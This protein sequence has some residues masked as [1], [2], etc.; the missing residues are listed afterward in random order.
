[1]RV[2][3]GSWTARP[4][5]VGILVPADNATAG[6]PV[7]WRELVR[8]AWLHTASFWGGAGAVV[9]P[10]GERGVHAQVLRAL[11]GYDPD[12]VVPYGLDDGKGGIRRDWIAEVAQDQLRRHTSAV[13]PWDELHCPHFARLGGG[14]DYPLTPMDGLPGDEPDATSSVA[15][16]DADLLL[17]VAARHGWGPAGEAAEGAISE[18]GAR[19]ALGGRGLSSWGKGPTPL[20]RTA[21]GLQ[22]LTAGIRRPAHLLLV[23][24][25]TVN[26]HC[27]AMVLDRLFG[28]GAAA[29]MPFD[30]SA[31]AVEQDDIDRVAEWAS[32]ESRH[33][34]DAPVVTSLT[35]GEDQLV[36]VADR[37]ADATSPVI[38]NGEARRYLS[39]PPEVRSPG[40][41]SLDG[42]RAQLVDGHRLH[43]P[44]QL[45]VGD[46]GTTVEPQPTPPIPRL[47]DS[48][49][50]RDVRWV[51]D[52]QVDG[53]SVP[54]R[55]VF[56][57]SSGHSFGP[58]VRAG[59]QG[60][61]WEAV[62]EFIGG[63]DVAPLH[64]LNR[65]AVREPEIRSVISELASVGS[66]SI[67]G[68]NVS[69]FYNG[70]VALW[71]GIG[72]LADDLRDQG[73][74]AI[75]ELLQGDGHIGANWKN[76][77]RPAVRLSDMRA[78]TSYSLT[79][80]E[81]RVLAQ[82]WM[83]AGILRR[84]FGLKCTACRFPAFY[85]L[86]V[87]GESWECERCRTRQDLNA[88]W[89]LPHDEPPLVYVIDEVVGQAL[90]H[91]IEVPALALDRAGRATRQGFRHALGLE[92]RSSEDE[93]ISDIDYA[94]LDG[95]ELV[96]GEAKSN[97][98]IPAKEVKKLVRIAETITA[99]R[100]EFAT[101]EATWAE[102]S[103]Q[104]IARYEGNWR[105]RV[106]S[107]AADDFAAP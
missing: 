17:A 3:R 12:Y 31:D 25:S 39:K 107:I 6:T 43:L 99:D 40:L 34:S 7:V 70:T 28:P 104:A 68:S 92:V 75:L 95:H 44:V 65:I 23:V 18:I 48:H 47:A 105:P 33:G 94:Y 56:N 55:G 1:M 102:G 64:N 19:R 89:P 8:D 53:I 36:A 32:V 103:K 51:V 35:F 87:V 50:Y 76:L 72:P 37:L 5:R 21:T 61:S 86:E 100:L 22:W 42:P 97:G 15:S 60:W 77:K 30:G 88:G 26:D 49:G 90:D 9:V 101:T 45:F 83:D 10:V 85:S 79:R 91:H 13:G 73:R 38:V 106:E 81:I 59:Q 58:V 46:D 74:M 69:S 80:S 24:G 4:P 27:F 67:R 78:A 41:I 66:L 16:A 93:E 63:A 20:Q 54:P 29:W 52:L 14:P 62:A 84:G 11:S 2:L 57:H 71:G 82:T 96:L 98:K